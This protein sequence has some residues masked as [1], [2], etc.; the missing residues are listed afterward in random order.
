MDKVKKTYYL[1]A[2]PDIFKTN[3]VTYRTQIFAYNKALQNICATAGQN[4]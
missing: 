1:K 4:G 3:L 2:I